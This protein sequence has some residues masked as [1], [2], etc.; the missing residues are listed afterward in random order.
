LMLA[1]LLASLRLP[2]SRSSLEGSQQSRTATMPGMAAG[3]PIIPGGIAT[4]LPVALPC[5]AVPRFPI[6]PGGIA[7]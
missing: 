6:I 7:T 5:H 4:W 3:F 2:G 1:R